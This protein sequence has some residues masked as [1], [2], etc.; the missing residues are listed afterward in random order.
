MNVSVEAKF[1]QKLLVKLWMKIK[2][3]D[4]TSLSLCNESRD[5]QLSR[6]TTHSV[7]LTDGFTIKKSDLSV[8]WE[9]EYSPKIH[10]LALSAIPQA[11]TSEQVP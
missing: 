2:D 8:K 6:P 3:K 5:D 1:R 4:K 10:P 11:S 9:K 7:L